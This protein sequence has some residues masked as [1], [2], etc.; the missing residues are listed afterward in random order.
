MNISIGKPSVMMWVSVAFHLRLIF[1]AQ[2]QGSCVFCTRLLLKLLAMSPLDRNLKFYHRMN[3]TTLMQRYN[4]YIV[5][6][7]WHMSSLVYGVKN[8]WMVAFTFLP[9]YTEFTVRVS[10]LRYL[11]PWCFVIYVVYACARL[12][13][14]TLY[15]NI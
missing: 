13:I 3:K 11:Y 15:L 1:G 9:M 6:L 4:R 12:I 14:D 5:Q 7:I 2:S 8:V 10:H